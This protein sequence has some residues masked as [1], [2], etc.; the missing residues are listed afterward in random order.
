MGVTPLEEPARA[1]PG[2][3][4]DMTHADTP[5]VSVDLPSRREV[6][7]ALGEARDAQRRAEIEQVALIAMAADVYDWVD[8]DPHAAPEAPSVLH[9]ERLVKF[10]ADGTPDVA[11]FITLEVGPALRMSPQ[12][13]QSLICDVLNLRHRLP[14]VWT[15][16][17]DD[18]L[19]VRVARA[20]ARTTAELDVESCRWV[21]AQLAPIVSGQSGW[22]LIDTAKELVVRADTVRA[23]AK[24]RE[25]LLTR[26]VAIVPVEDA[27]L[28]G[29]TS[30]VAD[31]HARLDLADALRLDATLTTMAARL[32]ELDGDTSALTVDQRRARA[33]GMLADP[34]AAARLLGCEDVAGG[35][36]PVQ[37]LELVVHLRR[38][39]LVGSSTRRTGGVWEKF[40]PQTR[41]ALEE[42]LSHA[43]TA[44]VRMRP[45][46]DLNAPIAVT[47]YRPSAQLAT[48][49]RLRDGG[50]VFPW[51]SRRA[52]HRPGAGALDIDHTTPWPEGETRLDNLGLLARN[53]H[54]AVTHGGYRVEQHGN[55][56][57][58]WR[59]PTGQVWWTGPHGT[60]SGPPPDA[61]RA[62]DSVPDVDDVT[63]RIAVRIQ[64]GL[65][66]AKE[67]QA[68]SAEAWSEAVEHARRT[69]SNPAEPPERPEPPREE[70][71]F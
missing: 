66:K 62:Y 61:G 29:V 7:R 59:T 26:N 19:E 60:T 64:A 28:P 22:K 38:S 35:G 63:R 3:G 69:R 10:G 70:P 17:L 42:L 21:D 15:H 2:K 33:L 20:I 52:P 47:T 18:A 50:E 54:R 24:R 39:D 34:A 6:I 16:L 48:A 40:G 51:S 56:V 30:G 71:P 55:G 58:R 65:E 53:T 31:V 23:E 13:A 49:V 1:E 45:V 14:L 46:I 36:V 32:G 5:T 11:E 68:H 43:G 67:H 57:F 41:E 25:A 12:A 8:D 27:P 37:T 4:G 44:Q 9:G